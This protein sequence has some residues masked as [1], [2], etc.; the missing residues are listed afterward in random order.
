MG[1][2]ES[3]H[4]VVTGNTVKTPPPPAR[5]NSNTISV[6][7][8]KDLEVIPEITD[9]V[10]ITAEATNSSAPPLSLRSSSSLKS[11]DNNKTE[12]ALATDNSPI[13]TSKDINTV[14]AEQ[15][16]LKEEDPVPVVKSAADDSLNDA[17]TKEDNVVNERHQR[18]L[19][20]SSDHY[21]SS[22]KDEAAIKAI[23]AAAAAADNHGVEKEDVVEEFLDQDDDDQSNKLV[24]N[25]D[26]QEEKVKTDLEEEETKEEDVD[27]KNIIKNG[28]DGGDLNNVKSPEACLQEQEL[29]EEPEVATTITP[30]VDQQKE[31][32]ITT[33]KNWTNTNETT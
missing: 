17:L 15:Q 30:M 6:K 27:D 24:S 31:S 8:S 14:N 9:D 13:V 7:K 1:C 26:N 19:S 33:T 5:K 22:R 29:S 23:I 20:G 10:N 3:K 18:R 28:T 11:N 25:H 32:A 16:Q 12:L 2:N 4:D 21:F